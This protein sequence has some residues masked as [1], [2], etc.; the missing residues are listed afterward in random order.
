[1]KKDLLLLLLCGACAAQTIPLPTSKKLMEP[2]PG[3]P[4][5]LNSLPMMMAWSPDHR[6]L[7]MVNAG[8]GTVESSYAQSIAVLDTETQKLADF[9]QEQTAPGSAQTLYNGLA[10]SLDGSHLYASL[11]SLAQPESGNVIA[12]YRY[13]G[14][15]LQF[16]R[17]IT[18][19]LQKLAAGHVQNPLGGNVPA[20]MAI[21]VPTGLAVVKGQSGGEEV[22]VADEFSD[23]VLLMDAASGKVLERF[24]FADHAMVPSEYPITVIASRD[25]RRAFVA[26]WNGSAVAELDLHQ[27]KIVQKLALLPPDKATSPGSHPAALVLSPD[28][29]VLYVA[30]ANRDAVAAVRLHGEKMQLAG[31]YNTQLPGQRY[32]GAIPEALALSEDGRTL[33]VANGGSDAVALFATS[34]LKPGAMTEAKGF[35]PTEWFPTALAVKGRHLY[36]AAG[37]GR[38]TAA[39]VAPQPLPERTWGQTRRVRRP[40]TYIATMLHG[41]LADVDLEQA[42]RELPRLTS[43]VLASNMMEAASQ[44]LQFAGGTNPIHH[45]IYIIKENRTYDQIFGDLGVGNGDPSLTMYGKSITP[46][47]HKLALQFGVLDNFYDSGEVSGDGHVWSNAA[48]SSDYTEKTWQQAYRGSARVYDFEGIVEKGNPYREGIPDVNEPASS[49]IWTDLA[50]HGKTLYHFGEYIATTFCQE[51]TEQAREKSP[52]AGTP[53][54][55]PEQ[56]AAPVI[57]PGQPIPANYGGGVSRYPWDIPLIAKNVATKPELEGHFDP[58]Y[59][60]FELAFPDQLRVEEFLTHFRRW[61]AERKQGQDTMPDFVML[62][63]PNDHTAG[64]RPGMPTPRAS[65]A[66][67]DLAVGR[68]VEAVSHSPYW[69]DTAFFILEDDAQD[70]AD[71]VDAHRSTALIISKYAPRHAQPLVD[72]NF[73]TTVSFLRT[74]EDLLGIPPMNNNDALAPL[75]SSVFA[76]SGDQPPFDADYSNRDNGLIYTANTPK[77]PGAKESS[78]MD[79]THEDRADPVKLNVILWRDAMGDRPVPWMVLHPHN[80]HRDDDDGGE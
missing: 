2:V 31:M 1:M 27:G 62:R 25:G 71:H 21:P 39:N 13:D 30:L 33:Y 65:I 42:Q 4:Q 36:V 79:F 10:F 51:E 66:D 76:G 7:A 52:L 32:F 5:R 19:P 8:Y 77:S 38:G 57:H 14:T 53:E 64:T 68:A 58:Q 35:L 23:D 73:Y 48:I 47:L 37:K 12:V 20:G 69:D 70:G 54:P 24:D 50:K 16:E 26:L 41:S 60:D 80:G 46:N 28:E 29:K 59:P 6:H 3:S 44:H 67:N 40:H 22:L 63:L 11:D 61:V 55:A 75:I 72:P 78:R 15:T 34:E 56:C 18:V 74:M 9:P 17:N 49:Y 45:V 43:E